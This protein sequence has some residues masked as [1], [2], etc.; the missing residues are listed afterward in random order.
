MLFSST[1][2]ISESVFR[3]GD[4]LAGQT[5]AEADFQSKSNLRSSTRHATISLSKTRQFS[6]F[7]EMREERLND[8]QS[9]QAHN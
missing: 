2:K 1:L 5:I 3:H 9:H 7:G 6:L 8:L 4:E